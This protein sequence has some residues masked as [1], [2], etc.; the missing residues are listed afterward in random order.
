MIYPSILSADFSKLGFQLKALEN[1][2]FSAIHCDIMDGHFVPNL[3][4]GA[5]VL[6]CLQTTLKMDIHLMVQQPEKFADQFKHLPLDCITFHVESTTNAHRLAQY[7]KSFGCKVGVSL[8]PGTHESTIEHLLPVVDLV[9]VMTVNPGF[10][11]QSFI[12]PQLKKIEE[13]SKMITKLKKE[14]ILQVDGGITEKTL[15][16]VKKAGANCFVAGSYVF[17]AFKHNDY[18]ERLISKRKIFEGQ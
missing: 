10:G 1:A 7:L 11:G 18:H 8:N 14:I 12:E 5:P 2:G 17:E 6:S 16:L 13:I 9:L 3:T 4:F 15:P